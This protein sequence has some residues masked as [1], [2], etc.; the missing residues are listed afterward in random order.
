MW[1]NQLKTAADPTPECT[2]RRAINA[3]GTA[4]PTLASARYRYAKAIAT[5]AS[6]VHS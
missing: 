6:V 3:R 5:P 1:L 2:E 4:K